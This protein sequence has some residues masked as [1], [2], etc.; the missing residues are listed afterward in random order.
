M[1]V[2]RSGYMANVLA[3]VSH[4]RMPRFYRINAIGLVRG[5]AVQPEVGMFF[6]ETCL[7]RTKTDKTRAEKILKELGLALGAEVNGQGQSG[8]FEIVKMIERE[9]SNAKANDQSTSGR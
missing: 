4:Y 2:K 1:S 3:L 6:D 5:K 7:S 8:R 9:E